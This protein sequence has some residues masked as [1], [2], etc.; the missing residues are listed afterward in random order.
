[1]GPAEARSKPRR[2]DAHDAARRPRIAGLPSTAM[3][4]LARRLDRI[5]PLHRLV[6]LVCAA[7]LA[8]FALLVAQEE[9]WA[10][11]VGELR[12]WVFVAFVVAGELFPIRLPGR[13]FTATP[14]TTF[15]FAILLTYGPGPA[16]ATLA[17]ASVLADLRARQP[18]MRVAYNAAQYTL[19]LG[20][21]SAVLSGLTEVPRAAEFHFAAQDLPGI[22]LAAVA[23]FVVN[24]VAA[25]AAPALER[26]E[27][28]PAYLRSDLVFQASSAAVLLGFAPTV[29]VAADY[30]LWLIPLLG[31]PIAYI[32]RGGRDA[33]YLE[34]QALHDSLTDLPNRAL[35]R[36]RVEQAINIARRSGRSVAVMI[37]DLDRFKEVN[38]TLGHRHG[39]TLL[40]QI[41]PRLTGALRESDTIAR[42]GGDEF[43][44]LIPEL[45]TPETSAVVAEKLLGA[46][47]TPFPIQGLSLEIGASAGIACFPEHGDDVDRLL[48]RADVAMYRAKAERSGH[49]IY[50]HEHDDHSP[51]RLALAG[52]LRQAIAQGGLDLYYQPKAIIKTGAVSG[53]EA[54]VRWNHPRRGLVLPDT[55]IPLA[56]HTGLIRALTDHV[57]R[58]ALR[59][60]RA[61]R[62][63]GID[64]VISAN[65][66]AGNLLDH[67][68]PRDIGRLLDETGVAPDRLEL[69]ITESMLMA[70]ADRATRILQELRDMGVALSIDDFGTGYSSL[71]YLRRLP[72]TALKIDKAFVRGMAVGSPD[73][74]I[75]RSTID[76]GRNLGLEVIAEGVETRSVWDQLGDLG[77]G[78]AQGYYLSQPMP[79]EEVPTWLRARSGQTASVVSLRSRADRRPSA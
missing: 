62:E 2:G 53:M 35:F 70:D 1:M 63:E 36:D 50:A 13:N 77:C 16:V 39:D 20:A 34:Y 52:E 71:A 17:A 23:Y 24:V 57:L 42:L 25:G 30:D 15:A 12:F 44:I 31:L 67:A 29:V 3:R 79:A 51:A 41:G 60:S 6:A 38:D 45:A 43:G 54:L 7:G 74:M 22:L 78:L 5:Q 65:I 68:L 76:L 55:F 56:E 48:Q 49:E 61:W 26:G 19:A 14:S 33:V 69:E 64:L 46:L 18:T 72:V 10:A 47:Q 40:R 73:A 32:Y 28:V 66:S 21:A 75:V 11:V 4:A 37:V 27:N 8:A 58:S 9:D 59:Q